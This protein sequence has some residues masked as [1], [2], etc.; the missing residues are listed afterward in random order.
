MVN[1]GHD[2]TTWSEGNEW[3]VCDA[4]GEVLRVGALE[5]VP[6]DP[7]DLL[8]Q[9]R[10]LLV[11]AEARYSEVEHLGPHFQTGHWGGRVAAYRF[12]A[13]RVAMMLAARDKDLE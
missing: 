13:C 3:C 7:R 10:Q 4:C 8:R 9:L 2:K 1:C 5:R 12:I 6:A 11:A